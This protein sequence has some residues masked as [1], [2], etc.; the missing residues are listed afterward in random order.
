MTFN[1][2]FPLYLD[3][4]AQRIV[5]TSTG[6]KM[7]LGPDFWTAWARAHDPLPDSLTQ[8]TLLQFALL[9]TLEDSSKIPPTIPLIQAPCSPETSTSSSLLRDGKEGCRRA[10]PG[11]L[12]TTP[13]GGQS[14]TRGANLT[15]GGPRTSVR[16]PHTHTRRVY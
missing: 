14:R 9:L 8:E 11:A 6:Q 2:L 16:G 13:P 15:S 3:A 12:Q 10:S 5:L 4:T 7:G 1:L